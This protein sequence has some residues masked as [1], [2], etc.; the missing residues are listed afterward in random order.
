MPSRL[1]NIKQGVLNDSTNNENSFASTL[2]TKMTAESIMLRESYGDVKKQKKS[3]ERSSGS[4]Q[5]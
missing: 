1:T 4:R 3:R 2:T 5:T